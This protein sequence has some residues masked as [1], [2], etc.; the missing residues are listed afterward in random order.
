MEA[1]RLEVMDCEKEIQS[2]KT[3]LRELGTGGDAEPNSLVVSA[4]KVS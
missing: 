2:V 1:A 4:L 3:A